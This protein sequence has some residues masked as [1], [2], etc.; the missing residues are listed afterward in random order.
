MKSVFKKLKNY[1]LL[2]Y[3]QLENTSNITGS[4]VMRNV[5]DH[6]FPVKRL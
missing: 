2:I 3:Y 6:A 4:D 1:V 5:H